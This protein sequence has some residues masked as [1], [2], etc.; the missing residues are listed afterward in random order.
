MLTQRRRRW[1]N[2]EATIVPRLV[3]AGIDHNHW[4]YKT[5]AQRWVNVQH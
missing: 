2:I 5:P 4:V 3:F 1:A